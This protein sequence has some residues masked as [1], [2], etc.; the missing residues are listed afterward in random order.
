MLYVLDIIKG[1]ICCYYIVFHLYKSDLY[2]I[3]EIVPNKAKL[4]LTVTNKILSSV[5]EKVYKVSDAGKIKGTS[6]TSSEDSII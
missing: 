2:L 4:S 1:S 5:F 3:M 6:G